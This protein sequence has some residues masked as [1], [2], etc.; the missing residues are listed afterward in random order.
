MQGSRQRVTL[1]VGYL[2]SFAHTASNTLLHV[3]QCAEPHR[4]AIG[5]AARR[6][7]L[8]ADES[9]YDLDFEAGLRRCA[10]VNS[11]MEMAVLPQDASGLVSLQGEAAPLNDT[12]VL[13]QQSSQ[14]D[15]IRTIAALYRPT[16]SGGSPPVFQ[17]DEGQPMAAR[18]NCHR[19]T[20]PLRSAIVDGIS[21]DALRKLTDEHAR[22]IR[23]LQHQVEASRHHRT[24]DTVDF[25]SEREALRE[26]I[27]ALEHD[28]R[29]AQRQL[30]E[31]RD[32]AKMHLARADDDV[33]K[34][35]D[36]V[37]TLKLVRFQPQN[38]VGVPTPAP[39]TNASTVSMTA[40]QHTP[41]A[42]ERLQSDIARNQQYLANL[43]SSSGGGDSSR[44]PQRTPHQ[45]HP[46]DFGAHFV[47]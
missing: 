4:V 46:Q 25:Y 29:Q 14:L 13:L 33:R 31:E 5:V 9:G 44:S 6:V 45:S 15:F 24:E 7:L 34:A 37:T 12:D 40:A 26:R 21:R 43:R 35:R 38:D 2:T 10:T 41:S 8:L 22:Q 36:E 42:L 3:F 1:Q 47:L 19:R 17:L 39:R 18:V 32:A 23:A 20:N 16:M 28:L 11:I 30:R 27:A